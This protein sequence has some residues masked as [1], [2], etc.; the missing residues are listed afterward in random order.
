M[1]SAAAIA[2]HAG[3]DTW[4]TWAGR[5]E[6]DDGFQ[7]A[8]LFNGVAAGW[9]HMVRRRKGDVVSTIFCNVLCLIQPNLFFHLQ[10]FSFPLAVFSSISLLCT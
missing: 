9:R 7:V 2:E 10:T 5:R 3:T 6:G 8:D 4:K 1:A